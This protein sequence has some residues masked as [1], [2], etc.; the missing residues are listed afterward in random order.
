[1][2]HYTRGIDANAG[3]I[4]ILSRRFYQAACLIAGCANVAVGARRSV[5]PQDDLATRPVLRGVRG[6][7]RCGVHPQRVGMGGIAAALIVAADQH[8]A[9][10][11]R[12]GC[13]DRRAFVQGDIFAGDG[14]CA[15]AFAAIFSAGVQRPGNVYHATR[16]TAQEDAA[17]FVFDAARFDNASLINDGIE[18]RVRGF[19][20]QD[21]L[22]TIGADRLF[23]FDPG[24]KGRRFDADI[25]Q[26]AGVGQAD[27]LA[28]RHATAPCGALSKPWLLTCLA[29]SAT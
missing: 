24:I 22:V 7:A 26:S 28:R 20:A 12:A 1:M 5:A 3:D 16:S 25:E 18:Q 9:A 6:N 11:N 29:I 19:R 10:G 4:E 21:H 27:A 14:H 2:K 15:A 23:I 13:V 17:I 8:G